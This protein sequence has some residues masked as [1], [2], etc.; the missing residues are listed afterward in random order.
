MIS[1]PQ[2]TESHKAILCNDL[3]CF[4][5]LRWDFVYQRP[6]HLM[7]RFS[8]K[9][10]TFFVEEPIFT[11]DGEKYE[12][13]YTDSNIGIFT[14]YLNPGISEADVATR[15]QKMLM[16][17]FKLKSILNYCFWYYTP[18]ALAFTENFKP[19]F[20][21]YDCMDEL[22]AFKFA[23]PVLKDME[24]KLL[25]S[26]DIVFTGGVSLFNH[27]KN[28]HKNIYPFPSSIEKEHFA[29]ARTAQPDPADQQKIPHPR[30]GYY[31]VIDERFDFNLIET[32]A[33]QKPEWQFIIIGPVVK[34]DPAIL[35]K[36]NNIHFLP[37]KTYEQLPSYVAGWEIALV[38]FARNE[39]TKFI[40]PTKTP[41]YLAA[42]KP[43]ISTSIQDVVE[44]YGKNN[45]VYIA[46]EPQEFI[47]A[48][49]KI[50]NELHDKNWLQKVDAFL[51]GNSWDNTFNNMLELIYST[52]NKKLDIIQQK[53]TEAYV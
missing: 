6:Q 52:A 47:N 28:H 41:E 53:K 3:I 35:P 34:I 5:H 30:F 18:M 36:R 9:F 8:K 51:D 16:D 21:V 11:S 39:S 12:Y 20:T 2:I 15:L 48:G 43:V 44:P 7:T 33:E 25:Q 10:R 32:V 1:L 49:E 50:L 24:K 37:G 13:K 46:D 38:P 42:G 40:S 4:S 17:F 27:K 45:L 22:S 14:P 19:H 23:P 26:A 29:K 31:G